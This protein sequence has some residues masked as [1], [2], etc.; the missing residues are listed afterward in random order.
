MLAADASRRASLLVA[1]IRPACSLLAPRRAGA[2]TPTHGT[3]T[4]GR[5]LMP[6]RYAYWTIIAGGLPTAFR[7]TEREE[8][9]PTFRRIKQKHPD[10]EMKYFAR[11]RLWSSPDEAR[12]EAE[13][14][15]AAAAER[16]STRGGPSRGR[17]WRPG[18]EHQDPRQKFKDAKKVRN[19]DR[20]QE[21]FDRRH[22]STTAPPP[23]DTPARQAPRAPRTEWRDRGPRTNKPPAPRKPGAQSDRP[24]NDRGPRTG[25]PA[26]SGDRPWRDR[27]PHTNKPPAPRKPGAQSDRP[28]NDRG[29][30][31]SRPPAAGDRPWRDRG[32]RTGK[33]PASGD[34]PWR[35]RPPR[36]NRR[37]EP[38]RSK[39]NTGDD[40]KAATPRPAPK[41]GGPYGAPKASWAR[42]PA[43]RP[44]PSGPSAKPAS[45]PPGPPHGD[46]DHRG[47]AKDRRRR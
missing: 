17:T 2:S 47:P 13:A 32:P 39:S 23:G 37:G 33:P 30:R 44:R 11:G 43:P 42:K 9:L 12:V 35:D 31:T 3:L 36:D 41:A 45:R 40:R 15:R 27:A 19:Q 14:R 1:Y 20:R 29:P 22:Q 34:R 26:P 4:P 10:A 21:R 28:W 18:G 5:T 46:R 16:H 25:K 7:T 24:W 6:P 8:L 38:Y